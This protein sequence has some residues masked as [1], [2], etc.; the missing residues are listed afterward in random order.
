MM[1]VEYH[2]ARSAIPKTAMLAAVY[3]WLKLLSADRLA[4]RTSKVISITMPVAPMAGMN[5]TRLSFNPGRSGHADECS[6]GLEA[7]VLA[8]TLL[9]RVCR[10]GELLDLTK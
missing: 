5:K 4:P 2:V 9:N 1:M 10:V 8:R 7:Y 3:W 6:D